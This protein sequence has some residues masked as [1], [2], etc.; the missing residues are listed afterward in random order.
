M[1]LGN[2][3]SSQKHP[4]SFPIAWIPSARGNSSKHSPT[5]THIEFTDRAGYRPPAGTRPTLSNTHHQST[6]TAM[7]T[8]RYHVAPTTSAQNFSDS[9][10]PPQ[11]KSLTLCTPRELPGSR[12]ITS[13][14]PENTLTTALKLFLAQQ[15]L[16]LHLPLTASSADGTSACG[17]DHSILKRY[18]SPA[19]PAGKREFYL[20]GTHSRRQTA[21]IAPRTAP[22]TV[23]AILGI[24]PAGSVQ[25]GY[26]LTTRRHHVA[27]NHE[28]PKHFGQ[29]LST[30]VQVAG[31]PDVPATPHILYPLAS[32]HHHGD[33][34]N[35]LNTALKL[36]LAK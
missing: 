16:T 14:S 22:R 3:F 18:G 24:T 10:C 35:T 2:V 28:C 11:Y 20:V 30:P 19:G 21:L 15:M 23:P 36:F 34:K 33:P 13:A 8:R 26:L 5:D 17:L 31:E 29:H 27:P 25:T 9:I 32:R 1:Y 12:S 4:E 6:T 7:P